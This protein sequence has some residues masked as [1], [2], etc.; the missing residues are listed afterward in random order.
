IGYFLRNSTINAKAESYITLNSN[1]DILALNIE[2]NGNVNLGA[3]TI[4]ELQLN[5]S[6][7]AQLDASE[8]IVMSFS[9]VALADSATV[10]FGGKTMKA[11]LQQE[12]KPLQ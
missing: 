11:F 1:A 2:R 8:A 3:N 12:S 9:N 6:N 10:K 5:L 7:G 4:R